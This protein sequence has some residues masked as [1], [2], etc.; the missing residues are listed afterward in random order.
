METKQEIVERNIEAR[1]AEIMYREINIA[2]YEAILQELVDSETDLEYKKQIESLLESEK[3][4]M[5]K[6]ILSLKAN[7]TQL[8]ALG[9]NPTL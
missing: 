2:N 7:K 4:E 3:R 5:R 6:D 1:E 8:E 9:K